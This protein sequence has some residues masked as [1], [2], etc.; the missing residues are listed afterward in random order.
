M[1]S[2][3]KVF[4][5][6]FVAGMLATSAFA[7]PKM[8]LDDTKDSW[9]QIKFLGQPHFRYMS[10]ADD[11]EDF[12]LRR[13]RLILVGQITD[14]VKFF[15]ETDNDSKTGV[16]GST[17]LQDAWVDVRIADDHWVQ[18]GLILLPFSFESRSSAA[19]LLGIDYNA[20][21]IQIPNAFVWRNFGVEFHGQFQELFSYHA[22][23]FD[24]YGDA[25]DAG[26]RFVGHIAFNV[27]G[28]Q[29]ADGWFYSQNRLGDQSTYLM[30]GAGIDQQSGGIA[31]VAAVPAT[32]TTPAVAGT[33][34][35]DALA[36]VVDMQSS[37]EVGE[38]NVLV[39]GAFYDYD[40]EGFA[41]NTAF[42]EA[43]FMFDKA[44]ATAKYSLVD[45]DSGSSASDVTVG[46]HY[47]LKGNNARAGVE[48]TLGDTDSTDGRL[49]A[50]LQFLL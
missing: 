8:F 5:C 32:A 37:F 11:S 9:M 24:G 45:P 10:D 22:G 25:D 29:A 47:F 50:G 20:E 12:Y 31:A 16:N 35:E 43:G 48:Y 28:K 4:A 40:V 6:L 41:G 2:V 1:S 7:G 19:S 38:F 44:M 15:V 21:A 39:N 34:A 18:G 23:V 30:V 42:I 46:L 14:G 36:F 13:G 26:V 27:L 49:L 33:P 3:W 17:D